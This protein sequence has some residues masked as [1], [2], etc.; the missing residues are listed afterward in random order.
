MEDILERARQT[1]VAPCSAGCP[2]HTDTRSYVEAIARGDYETALEVL[3]DANPFTSVCGR[4]CHHP[5]EAACRRGKVDGPVGLRAL[6]RFVVEN[7]ND[8]REARR[9][10]VAPTFPQRVAI[11]G[12]G[13]AGMTAAHDLAKQGYRVT[14]FE[15]AD[16]PGGMLGAAIP[17]YRLP[18]EAIQ[19]DIDD[20]LALGVELRTGVTVGVDLTLDDLREQGFSAFLLATGLSE[21]HTLDV[22]DIDSEGILLAMPFLRAVRLG[23]PPELGRRVIVVGGGNVAMD[24]ARSVRRLGVTEVTGICLESREEMPASSWEIEEAVEEGVQLAPSWGIRAVF[25]DEGR[26]RGL[27]LRKCTRVFDEAGRFSPTY[28]DRDVCTRLA[29]TVILAIGQ[30][31]D[32][33][34][35]AGSSVQEERPGRLQYSPATLATS[36]PGVFACGEVATGPGSAVEAVADGHR[37]ARAIAHTLQTNELAEQ[38]R[39][40]ESAIGEIP[41]DVVAKIRRRTPIAIR[42]SAPETRAA[43]FGEIEQPLSETEALAEAQRCLAC[44][45][46]AVVEAD[47]CAGCL[48]CVRICPF[49]VAQV[50][51]TAIMP[52]EKCQ[53]CGLCAAECPAAAIALERFGTN[54]M[55]DELAALLAQTPPEERPRPLIVSYC[56]L[57]EVTSRPYVR[58]QPGS[59]AE[60]GI[61]RVMVPCVARLSVP[62]LLAPFEL[63]ADAV[64]VISCA[65][66]ECLY[67]TGDDRLA[68]RIARV[69]AL[70]DEI[71]LGA[72][73]LDHWQTHGSAEI[74][75]AA[76]WEISKSKLQQMLAREKAG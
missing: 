58:Q 36:E 53:A 21:S 69:K 68:G 33:T 42:R 19:E 46:G 67:P 30:R 18:Y 16:T 35:I 12:S 24:V 4:I 14:V 2:V 55:K 74:S 76:F 34:C 7:T 37:A 66:D 71:G 28:D 65:D 3:L 13:P 8:H 23:A 62:D 20:I 39:A 44:T 70:L 51:K 54:R 27:E 5:C 73:R 32:L 47:R 26:V 57:F 6:K 17:R 25:A 45:V 59:L 40:A 9:C 15:R 49:G 63:G 22:P 48:T 41:A 61:A 60:T 50:D 31:A 64:V 56:C 29:D 10:P 43:S 75:W 11:V 38:P 52:E 72:E 1:R